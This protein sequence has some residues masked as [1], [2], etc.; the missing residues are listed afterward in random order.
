MNPTQKS[1]D[2][3]ETYP[4]QSIESKW[5]QYWEKENLFKAT[6]NP[7][8]SK[9]YCLVMFPY[10]SGKIHVGHVR[11]Y[12]IGD[13]IARYKSMRGY[14]ILH[15]I[16]WDAFGLPA[17]NAAME[18]GIHPGQWT[19][20]NIA[21]MRQQIKRLGISYDW[22]R[23]VNTST[24]EYYHWNQWFF[25]KMFEQGL[26]YKKQSFV[27]WC[28]SCLTVLAN[29]QVIDNGCWRCDSTVIQKELEQWFFKITAYAEQLL[30]D[31]DQL[32]GW[33]DRVLTMQRN[34]IGKSIG[35][36]ADFPLSGQE[37]NIRIFTTRQDTL[38]GATFMS[39]APEHPIIEKLI[40]GRSQ[41]DDVRAFVQ[42]IKE[43]DRKGRTADDLEKEG[44]FTGAFAINPMTQKPIPIW[45][46]N[47]VLMDYGTGAIMAVPAHDQ[48][49]FEFAKKYDLPIRLVIQNPEGTLNEDHLE[50][51]YTEESG[52]LIHSG[53][54]SGLSPRE[55]REKIADHLE[56]NALGKR[57]VSYRLRDWGVSR[58]RYW[59][60][61]IPIIYCNDCGLVPVPY[62]DLPV[63]LPQDIPGH[64][65][66]KEEIHS[67]P[68]EHSDFTK[69]PC[70]KCGKVGKRESD[71]MD[72]FVDSSWYFLRY[73]SPHL[74][75][76]PFDQS[77]AAQW[78][79]VDQYIGGIEHAVLHLLYARFFTKV[80][81]D[82][83][84]IT[85]DEPFL[86]LLTQGMVVKESN[87]C[88]EHGYLHPKEVLS[89]KQ[90]PHCHRPADPR[91]MMCGPLSKRLKRRTEKVERRTTLK[92][93]ESSQ[94]PLPST[95]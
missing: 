77:S 25:L 2:S 89:Q 14:S 78:M 30:S 73:V 38:F 66:T 33:P 29:E 93:K 42:K 10:P 24:A 47:F 76:N 67:N 39:L 56:K 27:N 11:N 92:K 20:D 36:E 65:Q 62:D 71:T 50:Q 26:A 84:L 74:N 7:S 44:I 72:T 55:A 12:V 94:G 90:C 86:R 85:F 60:A 88:S 17:E 9:F 49:D 3:R 23:E 48:R 43:K 41:A 75:T 70:P 22:D 53:P 34:W 8:E 87:R 6:D 54:F 31:C 61:P 45:V 57:T 32:T 19:Q 51:A 59:G 95:Q 37:G 69:V 82:M 4:S 35:A 21:T 5:Q 15:P 64:W 81:R 13:V 18:H 79:P 16:G 80:I 46:A 28:P 63:K 91:P 68:L 52:S 83:G 40:S 1:S 58:Q